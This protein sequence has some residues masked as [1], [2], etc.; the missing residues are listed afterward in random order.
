MHISKT[1]LVGVILLR[2]I[3]KV[4]TLPCQQRMWDRVMHYDLV[5]KDF[6]ENKITRKKIA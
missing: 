2:Q 5:G 4:R 3:C 6:G 1:L